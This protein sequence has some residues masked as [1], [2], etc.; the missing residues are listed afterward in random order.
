MKRRKDNAYD[1]IELK[2][3]DPIPIEEYKISFQDKRAFQI[4]TEHGNRLAVFRMKFIPENLMPPY[5][6]CVAIVKDGFL[7]PLAVFDCLDGT[8]HLKLAKNI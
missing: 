4:T 1:I 7:L 5:E 2:T 3:G 6:A 8:L